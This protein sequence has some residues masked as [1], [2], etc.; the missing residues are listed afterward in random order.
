MAKKKI[1]EEVI[2]EVIEEVVD[3]TEPMFDV[4]LDSDFVAY[5]N[6]QRKYIA[7]GGTVVTKDVYEVLKNA[8]K[9]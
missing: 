6:G 4:H 1:T 5:I 2:A 3:V 9:V 8:G 7:G